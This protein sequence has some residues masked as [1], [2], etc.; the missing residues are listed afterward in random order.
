VVYDR[1]A[2]PYLSVLHLSNRS[3][4]RPLFREDQV[5]SLW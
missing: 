1:D 3:G 4:P 2:H 5:G